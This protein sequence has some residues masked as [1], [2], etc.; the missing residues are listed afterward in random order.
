MAS[1]LAPINCHPSLLL[2]RAP[3]PPA[4]DL[5]TLIQHGLLALRDTLQQDK[6]LTPLNTSIGIVG[7]STPSTTDAPASTEPDAPATLG[8]APTG[9]FEK[10]RI[11]EGDELQVFLDALPAKDAP[12]TELAEPVVPAAPA[13]DTGAEG[14]APVAGDPAAPGGEAMDTDQ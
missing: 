11:I 9:G 13:A 4:A 12:E 3:S 14:G 8:A 5:P 10:F 1:S 2:T 6:D 7:L